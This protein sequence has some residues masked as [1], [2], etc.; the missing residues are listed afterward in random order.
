MYGTFLALLLLWLTKQQ[1]AYQKVVSLPS[2]RQL[3]TGRKGLR[4]KI[5]KDRKSLMHKSYLSAQS[6]TI[7]DFFHGIKLLNI[8]NCQSHQTSI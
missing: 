4:P 2:A 7:I 5:T 1:N 8:T 3:H 6:F